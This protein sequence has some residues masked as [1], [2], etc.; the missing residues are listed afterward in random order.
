ME[1]N[2]PVAWGILATGKIATVLRARPASRPGRP[3]RRRRVAPRGVGAVVR[4]R[5]RRP[6]P[7]VVRG[8]GDRPRGRGRVRRE[9]ARRAP[10]ARADGARGRQARAVREAADARPR[11]TPRRWCGWPAEHDRF[12]MEAMWMA[13]HPV[14]RALVDGIAAGRFG[15]PRQV[16]ADL[17]FV[18]P[19]TREPADDRPLAGRGRAARHG[20]LP[21]DLR[22][23]GARPGRGGAGRGRPQPAGVRRRRRGGHPARRWCRGRE[24]G[25]DDLALAPLRHHRD[26]PRPDRA[27]R[28]APPPPGGPLAAARRRARDDH[29]RRAA[30]GQSAAATRRSRSPAAWRPGGAR[31]RWCRTRRRCA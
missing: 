22:R 6:R 17:G 5:A 16:H 23:P 20:H 24:H 8:A 27:R 28:R 4:R 29:R 25:V 30:A 13:C 3:D 21:A 7:R 14:I 26:R 31:A 19:E 12:L 1:Q 2:V 9:P 10:R 15:T 18:V 11:P